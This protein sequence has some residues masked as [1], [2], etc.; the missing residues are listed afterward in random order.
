VPGTVAIT[1]D[2]GPSE[3]TPI[4]LDLLDK[5]DAKATFFINGNGKARGEIDV[6][7]P[8]PETIKRMYSKG[9]QLGSHTYT[10]QDLNAITPEQ[11][12]NQMI[13]NEMAFVKL[14]D[15]IPTYMRPPYS[16]CNSDCQSLMNDLGYHITYFDSDTED[17]VSAPI[18]RQMKDFTGNLTDGRTLVIAHETQKDSANIL[19]EFMLKSIAE[20][21]LKAVTVGECLGDPMENWYRTPNGKPFAPPP[22]WTYFSPPK[23]THDEG[24]ASTKPS[25]E[26]PSSSSSKINTIP[27]T[28]SSAGLTTS[29]NLPSSVRSDFSPKVTA[30]SGTGNSAVASKNTSDA[31]NRATAGRYFILSLIYAVGL[32]QGSI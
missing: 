20:K 16:K 12:N 25:E 1:Y 10:H 32:L 15:V 22:S 28:K 14:L 31:A 27:P 19:T 30:Q 2:D 29:T 4:I 5:Y 21:G 26:A 6:K 23:T 11:Q 8:W 18:N 17:T 7:A 13:Y 3:F 9:H 24:V